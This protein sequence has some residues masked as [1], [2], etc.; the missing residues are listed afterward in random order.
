MVLHTSTH[1]ALNLKKWRW[2]LISHKGITLE[3]KGYSTHCQ[4]THIKLLSSTTFKKCN[5]QSFANH[6]EPP[7]LNPNTEIKESLSFTEE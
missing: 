2:Y 1:F 3:L 5:L 7:F 4:K 6:S